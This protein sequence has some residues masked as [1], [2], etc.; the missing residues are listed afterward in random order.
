MRGYAQPRRATK[1]RSK[2]TQLFPGCQT[3]RRAARLRALAAQRAPTKNP[4]NAE[5]FRPRLQDAGLRIEAEIDQ[6]VVVEVY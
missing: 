4:Q 1:N 5:F 6:H 2:R 3:E